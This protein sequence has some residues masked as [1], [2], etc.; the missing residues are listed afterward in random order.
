MNIVC[1]INNIQFSK[2]MDK[3]VVISRTDSCLLNITFKI[4][5]PAKTRLYSTSVTDPEE[6]RHTIL[7]QSGIYGTSSG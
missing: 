2:T 7:S 4:S 1:I 6:F 3:K 5:R